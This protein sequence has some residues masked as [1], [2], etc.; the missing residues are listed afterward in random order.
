MAGEG[1]AVQAGLIHSPGRDPS[2]RVP[3]DCIE[4]DARPDIC[5]H[6]RR[7]TR[8]RRRDRK[9]W[10]HG[11]VQAHQVREPQVRRP[12]SQRWSMPSAV[13]PTV[14]ICWRSSTGSQ[15]LLDLNRFVATA[16]RARSGR[17]HSGCAPLRMPGGQDVKVPE[18][19]GGAC[20]LVSVVI[21][22]RNERQFSSRRA[23]TVSRSR[24]GRRICWKYWWS[25][26]GRPTDPG[27]S[28]VTWRRNRRGSGSWTI[29]TVELRQ[30]S[31]EALKPL[32]GKVICLFSSHGVPATDYIER[33]VAALEGSGAAGVGGRIEHAG[34]DPSSEAIGLAMTSPFGMASQ[35]RFAN[36]ATEIDTIGHPAYRRD[37]LLSVGSFD[38]SLERNSDY[39][40]NW[41]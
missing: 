40:L 6:R 26:A 21:P 30:R 35:F 32:S 14:R 24:H 29:P 16:R 41:R 19:T 3:A 38:E 1:L 23:S 7:T 15:T 5:R 25:T 11:L 37:A 8:G 31:T 4:R 20:R 10:E 22:M 18:K 34:T 33:S 39:E 12:T 27:R 28:S 2:R 9:I 17:R 36:V 13:A